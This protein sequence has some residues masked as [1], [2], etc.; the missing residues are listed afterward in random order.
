MPALVRSGFFVLVILT[1][2]MWNLNV[3]LIFIHP[4]Q[5]CWTFKN[6]S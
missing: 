6:I 1:G 4:M 2:I 5:R 3:V